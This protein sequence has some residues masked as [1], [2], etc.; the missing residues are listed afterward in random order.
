MTNRSRRSSQRQATVLSYLAP[1][2]VAHAALFAVL[3]TFGGG[4][5]LYLWWLSLSLV[6]FPLMGWDKLAARQG[7][8]RIPEAVFHTLGFAGAFAGIWVGMVVFRHKTMKPGFWA[9]VIVAAC[10]H[11][12]LS[13]I[14]SR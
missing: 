7:L 11:L 3:T 1:A 5:R 14:L 12:G 4:N 13:Y 6:A 9:T 8:L 10:L 2:L